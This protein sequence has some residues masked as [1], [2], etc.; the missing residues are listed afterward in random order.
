VVAGRGHEQRA[1]S[2]RIR[3]TE[4]GGSGGEAELAVQAEEEEVDCARRIV[5]EE[6]AQ[7]AAA[8]DG[9]ADGTDDMDDAEVAAASFLAGLLPNAEGT[10]AEERQRQ[11]VQANEE[12]VRQQTEAEAAAAAAATA[13]TVA[14]TRQGIARDRAGL[15][16]EMR[17][18]TRRILGA[19]T[20]HRRMLGV[21]SGASAREA[22]RAYIKITARIHPNNAHVIAATESER[23]AAVAAFNRLGEAKMLIA[24]PDSTPAREWRKQERER[25]EEAAWEEAQW[26]EAEREEAKREEAEREAAER[27]EAA[28]ERWR[29]ADRKRR[30]RQQSGWQQR[31][32]QQKKRKGQGGGGQQGKKKKR[33]STSNKTNRDRR[34]KY[35]K[36]SRG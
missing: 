20:D 27:E 7:E 13:A 19:G 36:G 1:E 11:V 34:H 28:R 10:E 3:T 2:S 17:A 4:A 24:E 15:Q 33:R 35:G 5:F 29:E 18:H 9:K 26:E 32:Q 14:Q 30:Q 22:A 31:G 23:A 16:D 8:T 6:D 25:Q 21:D 12:A